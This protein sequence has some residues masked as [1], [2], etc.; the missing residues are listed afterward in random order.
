V[1]VILGEPC[2]FSKARFPPTPSWKN[3]IILPS[4]I[5]EAA[6]IVGRV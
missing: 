6:G 5:K 4:I 3:K 1:K 2:F